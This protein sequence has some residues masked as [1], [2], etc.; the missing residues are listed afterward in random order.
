MSTSIHKI[1]D[2][3][4]VTNLIQIRV[5]RV[6]DGTEKVGTVSRNPRDPNCRNNR[7]SRHFAGPSSPYIPM[8]PT[9][10]RWVRRWPDLP[11]SRILGTLLSKFLKFAS[12]IVVTISCTIFQSIVAVTDIV[13]NK[14]WITNCDYELRMS[15][16][17]LKKLCH[18]F[19]YF[20][21]TSDNL[22]RA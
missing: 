4:I 12:R 6:P 16:Y 18:F 19:N 11:G 9:P 2:S 13:L 14:T 17:I 5:P 20:V 1:M 10:L 8:E 22:F 3:S 15:I 21:F 7:Y